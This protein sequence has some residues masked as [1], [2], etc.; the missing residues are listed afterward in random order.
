MYLLHIVYKRFITQ[1]ARDT[2]VH[3]AAKDFPL[4]SCIYYCTKKHMTSL[5]ILSKIQSNSVSLYWVWSK[6]NVM[7]SERISLKCYK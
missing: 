6:K 5:T 4:L 2:V 3:A 1:G 7:M